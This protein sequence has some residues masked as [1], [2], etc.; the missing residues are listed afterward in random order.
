MT[1]TDDRLAALAK[2]PRRDKFPARS[3]RILTAGLSAAA[4]LGVS[5]AITA[6]SPRQVDTATDTE[7]LPDPLVAATSASVANVPVADAPGTAAITTP[8]PI[9][10]PQAAIPAQAAP[11][12]APAPTRVVIEVPAVPVQQ[13]SAR[14][15]GSN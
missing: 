15:G 8:A 7:P 5:S 6:M 4:I 11:V 2:R 1:T 12:T 3:A 14:S 9:A 13:P 10:P